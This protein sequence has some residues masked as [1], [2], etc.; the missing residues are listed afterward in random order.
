M[1]IQQHSLN[2]FLKYILS[3]YKAT[4]TMKMIKT[5]KKQ[6]FK[7]FAIHIQLNRHSN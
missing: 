3:F 5:T 4:K 2:R 1:R 7:A 6:S